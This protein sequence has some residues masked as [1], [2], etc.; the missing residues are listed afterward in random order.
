MNG[1]PTPKAK[2]SANIMDKAT[3]NPAI[4]LHPN[5]PLE[6]AFSIFSIVKPK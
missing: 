3:M 4:I 2:L 6:I 5:D 1:L